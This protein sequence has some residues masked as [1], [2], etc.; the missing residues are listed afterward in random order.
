MGCLA[1]HGYL[2]API[3]LIPGSPEGILIT[4]TAFI[5]IS[6]VIRTVRMKIKICCA[7]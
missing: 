1:A 7:S 6:L 4:M 2:A 5:V 3:F